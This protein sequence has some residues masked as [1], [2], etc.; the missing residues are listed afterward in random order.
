MAGHGDTFLYFPLP[1]EFGNGQSIWRKTSE[2]LLYS[3]YIPALESKEQPAKKAKISTEFYNGI[4]F[5]TATKERF[6][7]SVQMEFSK[8][9]GSRNSQYKQTDSVAMEGQ[10]FKQDNQF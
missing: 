6:L 9:S 1:R 2:L 5:K 3:N 4:V 10:L 8:S 7:K